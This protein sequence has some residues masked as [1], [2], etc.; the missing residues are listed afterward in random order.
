MRARALV[1]FLALAPSA[2]AQVA[3]PLSLRPGQVAALQRVVDAA[4]EQQ[5]EADPDI[6]WDPHFMKGPDGRTY[7][8]FTVT[9]KGE[10]DAVA[11][12]MRVVQR[13]PLD[14]NTSRALLGSRLSQGAIGLEAMRDTRRMT[15]A[16]SV[17][18]DAVGI[19]TSKG[20]DGGRV[21]RTAVLVPPG[22]HDLYL[23]IRD[24]DAGPGDKTL[25]MKRALTAPRFADETICLSSL[26]R[27]ARIDPLAGPLR[28]KDRIV[29]PYVIGQA[30]LLPRAGADFRRS[31]TLTLAF[32]VYNA[33]ADDKGKPD[34]Q[35]NYRL[36]REGFAARR[37]IGETSPQRLDATTLPADFDLRAG[38]QLAP[39]QQFSLDAYEPGEYTVEVV[40]TDRRS[41]ERAADHALFRIWP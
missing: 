34:V 17:F 12:Y 40:V 20:E 26:V 4:E 38:N 2:A 24:R 28:D 21:F 7:V 39:I 3:R 41:G 22:V 8:P 33:A 37:A 10:A 25:L 11:V 6:G 18:Q 16:R 32:F 19:R 31:D 27:V 36:F 9:I 13:A 29:H 15:W 30:E 14:D 1:V 23:A 35:V 5:L